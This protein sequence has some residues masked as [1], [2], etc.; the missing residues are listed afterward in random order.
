MLGIS[1]LALTGLNKNRIEYLGIKPKMTERELEAELKKKNRARYLWRKLALSVNSKSGRMGLILNMAKKKIKEQLEAQ[2]KL[3]KIKEVPEDE[4]S[5]SD[6]D[7]LR[8]PLAPED[9][10]Q[11]KDNKNVDNSL[12]DIIKDELDF[13][14]FGDDDGEDGFTSAR[15]T[16][17]S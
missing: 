3:K 5:D 10:D 12:D 1:F 15:E 7:V 6:D 2:E 17:L 8:A 9:L 11:T 13:D 16:K 4:F 14:G